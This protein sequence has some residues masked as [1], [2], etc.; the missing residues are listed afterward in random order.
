MIFNLLSGN[1]IGINGKSFKNIG[2]DLL[3]HQGFGYSIFGGSGLNKNDIEALSKIQSLYDENSIFAVGEELS[4]EVE[5]YTS[6]LSAAGKETAG[7]ILNGSVRFDSLSASIAGATT[8][9]TALRIA[10]AALNTALM[11]G[12]SFAIQKV[13]QMASDFV[14]AN[15]NLHSSVQKTVS[16]FKTE[17]DALKNNSANFDEL[18]KKYDQLSKGVGSNGKNVS[19]STEQYQEYL[20]V[21]N[22]IADICPELISGYDNQNNAIINLTGGVEELTQAYND[23]KIAED[24][25]VLTDAADIFSDYANARDKYYGGYGDEVADGAQALW[26]WASGGISELV[27]GEPGAFTKRVGNSGFYHLNRLMQSDV[28]IKEEAAR[29]ASSSDIMDSVRAALKTAGIDRKDGESDSEWV[30][31]AVTEDGGLIRAYVSQMDREMDDAV[32]NMRSISEAYLESELLSGSYGNIPSNLGNKLL[33]NV[34]PNLDKTFF[35]SMDDVAELNSY[36]NRMLEQ[37]NDLSAEDSTTLEIAFDAKTKLNNGECSV[38]EYL[39]AIEDAQ[40]IIKGFDLEDQRTFALAIDFNYAQSIKGKRDSIL[41]TFLN[42]ERFNNLNPAYQ[43]GEKQGLKKWINGLSVGDLEIAYNLLLNTDSADW[44]LQEFMRR[45]EAAKSEAEAIEPISYDDF[46]NSNKVKDSLDPW[47][48]QY[49]DAMAAIDSLQKGENTVDKLLVAHPEWAKFADDMEGGLVK[50]ASDAR[51]E[52]EEELAKIGEGINEEDL[53]AFERFRDAYLSQ[54]SEDNTVTLGIDFDAESK[55]MDNVISSIKSSVSELGLNNEQMAELTKRYKDLEGFNPDELFERTTNGIHLNT[56]ALMQNESAYEDLM[57]SKIDKDLQEKIAQY[58]ELTEQINNATTATELN[59]AASQLPNLKREID[60]LRVMQSQYSALTS[61]YNKWKKAQSMGE[62]GDMYDDITGSLKDIKKLYEDGLIGTNKFRAAV[63]LMTDQD[64]TGK[65][66]AELVSIYDEAYPKMERYFKDG[67][68]G[69]TNFLTDIEKLG[70]GWATVDQNGNWTLDFNAEDIAKELGVS[71]EMV[72]IMTRKLK[73]FGFD[74]DMTGFGSGLDY[75]ATD[76]DDALDKIAQRRSELEAELNG[77]GNINVGEITAELEA[78]DKAEATLT[79]LRDGEATD[80]D[81]DSMSADEAKE[82]LVELQEIITTLSSEGCNIPIILTLQENE[83]SNLLFRNAI[84][85]ARAP[86]GFSER[87]TELGNQKQIAT[88]GGGWSWFSRGGSVDLGNRPVISSDKLVDMGYDT[89]RGEMATIFSHS[90]SIGEN[91]EIQVVLTPI[92]PNGDVLEKSTMD[93]VLDNLFLGS[94]G[95]AHLPEGDWGFDLSDILIAQFDISDIPEDQ[96]ADYMNAYGK[97]LSEAQA[98]YYKDQQPVEAPP[99]DTT[100][101]FDDMPIVIDEP[102]EVEADAEVKAQNVDT[103]GMF[104]DMPIVVDEPLDVEANTQV[105]MEQPVSL[106]SPEELGFNVEPTLSDDAAESVADQWIIE[107]GDNSVEMPV[108]PV[109][110]SDDAANAIVDEVQ[111]KVDDQPINFNNSNGMITFPDEVVEESVEVNANAE[112]INQDDFSEE[113]QN[114]LDGTEIST[115]AEVEVTGEPITSFNYGTLSDAGNAV[116]PLI[117]AAQEAGAAEDSI[118]RLSDAYGQLTVAM[119]GVRTTDPSDSGAMD[120]AIANLKSAASEFSSAFADLGSQVNIDDIPIDAD[121]SQA[122]ATIAA[123]SIPESE[124]VFNPNTKAVDAYAPSDKN[125]KVNFT[126]NFSRVTS[127]AVPTLHG[128]VEYQRKIVGSVGGTTVGTAKATGTAFKSGIGKLEKDTDALSG[129]L[130]RELVVRDGKFFTVGDNGAEFFR[131]KSGDIIFNASQTEEL[132]RT[133]KIRSGGGR[134]KVFGDGSAYADG[135]AFANVQGTDGVGTGTHV[136]GGGTLGTTTSSSSSKKKKKKKPSKSNKDDTS[137]NDLFDW[138]EVALA[139]VQNAISNL[140][141]TATSTFKSLSTRLSATDGQIKKTF[142]ELNRQQLGY[143]RYMQQA[144]SV[145]LSDDLKKRVQEGAIDISSYDDDTKKKIDEYKQWYDKAMACSDAIQDLH[146]SIASLYSDK[147][148]AIETQFDNQLS[149]IEHNLTT[150]DN[151]LAATEFTGAAKPFSQMIDAQNESIILQKQKL[152]ELQAALEVAVASGEIEEGSEAWYEMKQAIDSTKESIQETEI[153]VAQLYK[154]GF[155]AIADEFTNKLSLIEHTINGYNA[156]ISASEYTGD[157]KPFANMIAEQRFSVQMLETEL[158]KLKQSMQEAI[159]SGEITEGSEAWYEMQS[160]INSVEDKI[161]ETA[162][163]I[164][165]TYKDAFD[166]IGKSFDNQMSLIENSVSALTQQIS[167]SDYTGAMKPYGEII[168]QQIH[169]V[170]LLTDKLGNLEY[171]MENAINSGEIKEGSDAWYEMQSAIDAA[172]LSIEEYKVAIAS[173]LADSFEDIKKNYESTKSLVD[174]SMKYL[175]NVNTASDYTGQAKSFESMVDIQRSNVNVLENE[176]TSLEDAMQLAL[177]TGMIQEGSAQWKEMQQDINSVKLEL[178]ETE[179]EISKIYKDGFDEIEGRFSGLLDM[180][181]RLSKIYD[182][183]ASASQYNGEAKPFVEML[184]VGRKNIDILKDEM[185]GLQKS[186][187]EAVDSGAIAEGSKAWQDMRNKILD[188]QAQIQSAGTELSKVYKDAFDEVGKQFSN[189]TSRINNALTY[190]NNITSESQYSGASKPFDEMIGLRI[191]QISIL[192]NELTAMQQSMENAVNSGAIQEGSEAWYE[193]VSAIDSV[194]SEIQTTGIEVSK[195]YADIFDDVTSQ[196]SDSMSILESLTKLMKT[197]LDEIEARGYKGGKELYNE[198]IAIEERSISEQ[199][200]ELSDLEEAMAK[201]IDSGAIR[202]GSKQWYQMQNAIMGV[203]ESIRESEIEIVN[204][205]NA[206]RQLEWDAFDY[207]QDRIS[208]ITDEAEFLIK[209]MDGSDLFDDKGNPTDTGVATAGLHTMSYDVYMAQADKYADEIKAL[210]EEIANDRFDTNLITR[211]N[212]LLKLQRESI[213]AAEQ[214][215]QAIADLVEKGINIEL[216]ALSELVSKYEDSLDSAKDMYEYQRNI[217]KQ[218]KELAQLQKQLSAYQG[219]TS[220]ENR[221]RLQKLKVDI[222]DSMEELQAT[223]YDQY[224]ADQ[225]KML[226]DLV[227]QY[228]M[229]LNQRIDD[230]DYLL[231][232]MIDITNLNAGD[233]RATIES[234]CD[235]VGITITDSMSNIWSSDGLAGSIVTAYGN[236]MNSQLTAVNAELVNIISGVASLFSDTNLANMALTSI[237]N[238]VGYL[239]NV[240]DGLLSKA[241]IISSDLVETSAAT[242]LAI[243]T[244]KEAQVLTSTEISQKVSDQTAE[245][246]AGIEAENASIV[247]QTTLLNDSLAINSEGVK[248]AIEDS[249]QTAIA[250]AVGLE[251]DISKG[252]ETLKS[253]VEGTGST[254]SFGAEMIDQTVKD[255]AASMKSA[256]DLDTATVRAFADNTLNQIQ[257][258]N[259]RLTNILNYVSSLDAKVVKENESAQPTTYVPDPAPTGTLPSPDSGGGATLSTIVTAE[260]DNIDVG[261]SPTSSSSSSSSKKKKSSSKKS[262]SSS[263]NSSNSNSGVSN[264]VNTITNAVK[265]VATVVGVVSAVKKVGSAVKKVASTIKGKSDGGFFAEAQRTAYRNGDDIV[266]INT[267]KEGEAVLTQSEAAQFKTLTNYLPELQGLVDISDH[268]RAV[269]TINTSNGNVDVGGI[270]LTIQIDHVQD[271][272]DLLKQMRDDKNFEKMIDAMTLQKALG[273]TSFAKKKYY[274]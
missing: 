181:S 26:D 151:Q 162:T 94:D 225:K 251:T 145:D 174:Y 45:F 268:L 74:I 192:E 108:D 242:K 35:D 138:I 233:I 91:G 175:K 152:R 258:L 193:M 229:A 21:C 261:S 73:D 3:H 269:Q 141:K 126:A 200:S 10:T 228:E 182:G 221:A 237:Q 274:N 23:L 137:D 198:L 184:S 8:K 230:V 226:D 165:K 102:L 186:L 4:S 177:D 24:R 68:E 90:Q 172:R 169:G 98:E 264:V 50:T 239:S 122:L 222:S 236:D 13:V 6:A 20:S 83:L 18:A 133:G 241:D 206:I 63:Q 92:L 246:K 163:S 238:G 257:S 96:R 62:E 245:L 203:K 78:L 40:G 30:A 219:D 196:Y 15:E 34:I 244:A 5:E 270:D 71:V 110:N 58:E 12:V 119:D 123:I 232:Q 142:T 109:A 202:E 67:K 29:I 14:H 253:A 139:R 1:T 120:T 179:I 247:E 125:A 59:E 86:Q 52:A 89:V 81:I 70:K 265:T 7:L 42:S 28:D 66:A 118:K 173:T 155:D 48:K 211:R 180:T 161:K 103:T 160:K 210:N 154:D 49:Q 271:Y 167:A 128:V 178:Q 204:F 195:L 147:F 101:M 132:F 95:K 183:M 134:G 39:A 189:I 99:I 27:T 60:A 143:D 36:F 140:S 150:F 191:Q 146:E 136:S 88:N 252:A 80:L 82:K 135:T 259:E 106:P 158:V 144:N 19:L 114:E 93:T 187:D 65:S 220:E 129:E 64:L 266:T 215:K 214:E 197:G 168:E 149:D 41:D 37:L 84:S 262:S 267:L 105:G 17:H 107:W 224:V 51:T 16:E 249:R 104:D 79:A 54:F 85:G 127:A 185:Q 201:A 46:V 113:I 124:V 22:E 87:M 235:A 11:V 9:T 217:A 231:Q 47:L 218:T 32:S 254:L 166:D 72:E 216:D 75:Y 188:V 97:M 194:K 153:A 171:A 156:D 43:A 69:V 208:D 148:T 61:S 159:D 38:N 212:E 116:L 223:Q 273:K 115:T 199:K 256:I 117:N 227:D 112:V 240:E 272:N 56:E 131:F 250:A 213:L 33:E 248:Q 157:A 76:L 164:A 53:P 31:R 100:G 55:G 44:S 255:N 260:Q 25:V 176:L 243:D 170:E 130:G 209:L 2:Y 234:E 111:D 207:L 190:L 57:R 121:T 205:N 77:G 263:S